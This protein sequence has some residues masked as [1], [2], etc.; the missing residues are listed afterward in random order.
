MTDTLKRARRYKAMEYVV[1]WSIEIDASS[2]EDAAVIALDIQRDPDAIATHFE[3]KN[4]AGE[5]REL[6]VSDHPKEKPPQ[7][8]VKGET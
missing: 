8:E 4:S 1:T 7:S 6:S 5:V 2:F 3:V